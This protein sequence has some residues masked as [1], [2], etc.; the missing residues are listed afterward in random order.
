METE[1]LR[2]LDYELQVSAS[3]YASWIKRLQQFQIQRYMAR[4]GEMEPKEQS[5]T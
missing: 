5:S 2:A 3:E 4:R 1:F